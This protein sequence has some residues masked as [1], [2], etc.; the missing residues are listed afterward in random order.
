MAKGKGI[1]SSLDD[2]MVRQKIYARM[3]ALEMSRREYAN[4]MGYDH[5]TLSR[6][7]NGQRPPT[8][9]ILKSLGLRAVTYYEYA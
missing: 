1:P 4:L 2:D 3:E 6:F 5:T 9:P 8:K 7:L